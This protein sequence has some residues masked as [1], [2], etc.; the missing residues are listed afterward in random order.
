MLASP[1]P[2]L[3][4]GVAV[5]GLLRGSAVHR[6]EE[7]PC[8]CPCPFPCPHPPP[9]TR[10]FA[11]D[12]AP[13]APP[14]FPDGGPPPACF[15]DDGPPAPFEEPWQ[16]CSTVSPCAFASAWSRRKAVVAFFLPRSPP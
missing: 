8:P 3:V 14:L 9:C 5:C 7:L 1:S 6:I 10:L 2:P 11:S 15:P 4:A 13:S 12:V 16:Y